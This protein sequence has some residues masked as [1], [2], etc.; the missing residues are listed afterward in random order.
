VS[1]NV[2]ENPERRSKPVEGSIATAARYSEIGFI[3]PAAVFLGYVLG[4]LADRWLHT[5]W[6]YIAG[7]IFGAVVGFAGMI[8]SAT[9]AMR[10]K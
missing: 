2:P 7:V 6:I 4:R 8:R 1:E 5:H 10:D 9:S 3:I